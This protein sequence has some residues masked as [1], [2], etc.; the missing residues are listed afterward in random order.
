SHARRGRPSVAAPSRNHPVRS[1]A[2]TLRIFALFVALV[3]AGPVRAAIDADDAIANSGYQTSFPYA[4]S[5]T[6]GAGIDGLVCGATGFASQPNA[7]T[8]VWDAGGATEKAGT[9]IG[10]S[11]HSA[12]ISVAFFWWDKAD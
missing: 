2:L 8:A 7:N 9:L 3:A 5:V 4:M 6:L 10:T 12:G 1:I 11:R